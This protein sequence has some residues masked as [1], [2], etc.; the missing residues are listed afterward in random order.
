MVNGVSAIVTIAPGKEELVSRCLYNPCIEAAFREHEREFPDLG[1]REAAEDADPGRHPKH[2]R[3]EGTGQDLDA[4]NTQ[5]NQG[6]K[7]KI[8]KDRCCIQEHP[9]REEEY[10]R[11]DIAER[12]YVAQ[13]IDI[14]IRFTDDQATNECSQRKR[15]SGL[16]CQ[17]R[18]NDAD[19][20]DCNQEEFTAPLF[21]HIKKQPRNDPY[22]RTM[23]TR[24]IRAIFRIW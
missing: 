18:D 23:I 24:M 15:Q 13:C 8:V 14:V 7:A 4:E 9:N 11:K 6:N 1:K 2:R 22:P 17:P 16:A 21:C 5:D 19:P 3:R 10:G 20:G 12:D